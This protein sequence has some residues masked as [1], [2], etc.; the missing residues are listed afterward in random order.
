MPR[1]K[2]EVSHRIIRDDALAVVNI[3]ER[4]LNAAAVTAPPAVLLGYT[5]VRIME[6]IDADKNEYNVTRERLL[7]IVTP[8][9]T[10]LGLF[11][12]GLQGAIG[13]GV[14][15]AIITLVAPLRFKIKP[16]GKK[17]LDLIDALWLSSVMPL[18][19]GVLRKEGVERGGLL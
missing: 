4:V 15:S 16:D 18:I 12:Q 17:Q 11:Y 10:F 7:A 19:L 8:I 13:A 1:L 6:P 9:S 3:A 2:K 5:F 14:T